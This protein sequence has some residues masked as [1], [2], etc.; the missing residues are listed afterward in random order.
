MFVLVTRWCVRG[1]KCIFVGAVGLV[2][3]W[4]VFFVVAVIFP[5]LEPNIF[6]NGCKA[7]PC[8]P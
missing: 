7:S 2:E 8:C 4:F 1:A 3:V 5:A 6:S